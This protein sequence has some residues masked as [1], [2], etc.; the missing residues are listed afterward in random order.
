[1]EDPKQEFSKQDKVPFTPFT[2]H[3]LWWLVI[4]ALL[5][6]IV[7]AGGGFIFRTAEL[8]PL[9]GIWVNNP[10][11]FGAIFSL[12]GSLLTFIWR[13]TARWLLYEA[14]RSEHTHHNIE[15][16]IDAISQDL[17]VHM[18]SEDSQLQWLK[19]VWDDLR[20]RVMNIERDLRDRK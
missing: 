16:K 6:M 5:F 8:K 1:M 10:L 2:I 19:T 12:A 9:G 3:D 7:F 15:D 13:M 17:K 11:T 20:E 4:V 18:Q 14:A